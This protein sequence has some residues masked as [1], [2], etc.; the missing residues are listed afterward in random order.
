MKGAEDLVIKSKSQVLITVYE[1]V[2]D[3]LA[4]L[5]PTHVCLWINLGQ[6]NDAIR[7]DLALL[8]DRD[9]ICVSEPSVN[10]MLV[11]IAKKLSDIPVDLPDT[12]T[13]PI[14]ALTWAKMNK[15]PFPAPN[16]SEGPEAGESPQAAGPSEDNEGDGSP[17]S[18][19]NVAPVPSDPPDDEPDIG[20]QEPDISTLPDDHAEPMAEASSTW[21]RVYDPM[22]PWPDPVWVGDYAATPPKANLADIAPASFAAY[23]KD[24]EDRLGVDPGLLLLPAIGAAA[25]VA[26]DSYRIQVRRNDTEW[27]ERPCVW[28]VSIAESGSG[29]GPA[30]KAAGEGILRVMNV[31]VRKKV[32]EAL[33][34]HTIEMEK[35]RHEKDK[36]IKANQPIPQEPEE[37]G[38]FQIITSEAT[39]EGLRKPLQAS[40]RGVGLW[41]EEIT[42]WAADFDAYRAKGKGSD[43]ERWLRAY[44]GGPYTINRASGSNG[45]GSGIVVIHNWSITVVGTTT[46]I[47]VEKI[48]GGSDEDGLIQRMLLCCAETKTDGEDRLP[49]TTE[50]QRFEAILK[51]MLACNAL[52]GEVLKFSET[53]HKIRDEFEQWRKQ[54]MMLASS[55]AERSHFSKWEGL[56]PRLCLVYALIEFAAEKREP[57]GEIPDDCVQRVYRFFRDWQF[58]HVKAFWTKYQKTSKAATLAN[59]IMKMILRILR[60]DEGRSTI[61]PSDFTA[62]IYRE[63]TDVMPSVR[64]DALKILQHCNIIRDS[65]NRR[66]SKYSTIIWDINPKIKTVFKQRIEEETERAYFVRSTINQLKAQAAEKRAENAME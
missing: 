55:S 21:Q 39:T 12:I 32:V 20:L 35:W 14:Q 31:D 50:K 54:V 1:D 62:R 8:K 27:K 59:T 43:R 56:F 22:Q 19:S 47:N 48:V 4:G 33:K 38:D 49:N 64:D 29:K 11:G 42:S 51:E 18:I 41:S 52:S 37:P 2:R 40:N 34:N 66:P 25:T 45:S 17:F 46:P 16:S 23:L 61:I 3:K 10:G 53:G 9:V 30:Q 5:F 65:T 6:E 13:T 60:D 28:C 15:C 58:G 44:D 36:A 24:Q 26:D 63:Y 7:A 57:R